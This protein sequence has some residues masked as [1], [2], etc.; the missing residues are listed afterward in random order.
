MAYAVRPAREDDLAAAYA[1]FYANERRTAL[2]L[3]VEPDYPVPSMLRHIAA[4][5]TV[6]IAC[7]ERSGAVVGF[8]AR[9]IRG[10]VR[11]LTDLFVQPSVQSSGVGRLLLGSILPDDGTLS[12]TLSS[13]DPRALALYVRQGM[14]PRWPSLG[15]R[16]I[17]PMLAPGGDDIRVEQGATHDPELSRWD[18]ELSGRLRPDDLA[19]WV[20]SQAAVVLWL[21]RGTTR[22]GYCLV[23]R[24]PQFLRDQGA[25]AIG[26]LGVRD[27]A[28]AAGCLTAVVRYAAPWSEVVRLDVP[29][30]HPGLK[31]LLDGGF[32]IVYTDTFVASD[33][34]PIVDPTRYIGSGGDLF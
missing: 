2:D 1:V 14:R 17:R 3:P 32:H 8:A 19:Y 12:C 16:A 10:E 5:G 15:L 27:A 24:A 21:L 26:P 20:R 18:A 25:I 34:T 4:T 30:P 13:D 7:D 31:L 29:G 28:D 9:V 33:R 6:H 22:I 11:Y 23:R